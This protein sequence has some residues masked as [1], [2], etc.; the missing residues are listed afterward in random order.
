M[1]V[2]VLAGGIWAGVQPKQ[3]TRAPFA[4]AAAV[5]PVAKPTPEPQPQALPPVRRAAVLPEVPATTAP[6]PARASPALSAPSAV[7]APSIADRRHLVERPAMPF[8]DQ[9]PLAEGQEPTAPPARPVNRFADQRHLVQDKGAAM[10]AVPQPV[11]A[12]SLA[13]PG[14]CGAAEVVTE[15]LEGGRMRVQLVSP[16]RAGASL[17]LAYGGAVLT[18]RLDAAGELNATLD[19]F[20]GAA[21]AI[22]T[23]DDGVRQSFATRALDLDRIDKVAIIWSAPV[24]LDLHALEYGAQPGAVGHVWSAVPA[25]ATVARE[26]TDA[27]GRGRGFLSLADKGESSG[28]KVEVYT[29]FRTNGPMQ[30]PVHVMVDYATRGARPAGTTCGDGPHARVVFE[31]VT[32]SRGD[33]ARRHGEIAPRPCGQLLDAASRFM[34]L[35]QQAAR[36]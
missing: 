31:S 11:E 29:F 13:T 8:D 15:A 10:P 26:L 7:A 20:A 35:P 19:L 18:R 2:V 27:S 5:E 25:T 12:A 28:D 33:V 9:R 21:P 30:G 1:L 3:L 17:S 6:V 32:F 16:C 24:D 22:A 23:F 36:R 4:P 34:P 14:A